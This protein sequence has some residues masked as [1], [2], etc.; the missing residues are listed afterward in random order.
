MLDQRN[1]NYE[2]TKPQKY[3]EV[4]W[5]FRVL[6]LSLFCVLTDLRWF[7]SLKDKSTIFINFQEKYK[8]KPEEI[9]HVVK[10]LLEGLK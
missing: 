4:V 3:H 8:F 2:A 6:K 10:G 5:S 7:P 9:Q 1:L